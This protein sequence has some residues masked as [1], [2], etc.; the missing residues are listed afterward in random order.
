[1]TAL[2][3]PSEKPTTEPGQVARTGDIYTARGLRLSDTGRREPDEQRMR[4][5]FV[6]VKGHQGPREDDRTL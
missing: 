3:P 2:S 1:M 4:D 5:P 6:N